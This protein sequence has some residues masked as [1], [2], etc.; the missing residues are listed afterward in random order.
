MNKLIAFMGSI[1]IAS[2]AMADDFTV[3]QVWNYET[4]EHEAGSRLT[5]VQIDS[6][7]G[8]DIVHISVDGL[9]I[10]NSYLESGFGE[11]IS[12]LPISPEALESSVTKQIGQVKTLPDYRE[13]YQI[14]REAFDSGEGGVFSLSVAECIEFIEQTVN[15]N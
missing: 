6:L 4:R 13:G 7:H 3:G 1:L 9:R 8:Q 15:Q 5:I 14:W 2:F 10:R 12:H 11:H